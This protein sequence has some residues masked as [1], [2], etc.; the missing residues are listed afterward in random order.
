MKLYNKKGLLLGIFWLAVGLGGLILEIARPSSVKAVFIRDIVL[1][2][3]L[4]LFS[5]RQIVRAFSARASREDFL[6]ERDER[7]RYIR[8][9]TGCTM[10]KVAEALLL[11][12]VISSAAAFGLTRDEIWTMAVIVSGLTLGLLFIIELI[13]GI[14]YEGKE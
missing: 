5:L 9:K 14:H 2:S 11:I 7:N 10:F 8:L 12:W 13:V 3:L 1:F 4:L 6:E